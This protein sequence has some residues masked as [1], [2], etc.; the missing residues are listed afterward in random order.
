M[1]R[2]AAFSALLALSSCACAIAQSVPPGFMSVSSTH[3]TDFSGSPVSNATIFWA[4]VDGAGKPLAARI[5]TGGQGITVPV[6]ANIATGAF[7]IQVADTYETNP[8]NVCYSVTAIDNTDGQTLL[9]YPCV[10]PASSGQAW[11]TAGSGGAGG[12]CN[13]DSYI[14]ATPAGAIVA[15]G[16]TGPTGAT[17]PNCNVS[18]PPGYCNLTNVNAVSFD[19]ILYASQFAG[20]DWAGKIATAIAALPAGGGTI[21]VGSSLAGAATGALTVSAN[22]N[23]LFDCGTFALSGVLTFTGSGHKVEG[24]GR[25]GT[26]LKFTGATDG[27]VVQNASPAEKNTFVAHLTIETSNASGAA[28]YRADDSTNVTPP[29]YIVLEDVAIA[30]TGSGHWAYG[31]HTQNY[32]FNTFRDVVLTCCMTVAIHGDNS[33]NETLFDNTFV[34]NSGGTRGAE[35]YGGSINGSEVYWN[36]G[37]IQGASFSGS[38]LYVTGGSFFNTFGTHFEVTG[39]FSDG[40]AIVVADA[41]F[42]ASSSNM[43]VTFATTFTSVPPYVEISG[44]QLGATTL[45]SH[46]L[47]SIVNSSYQSITNNSTN[48]FM[49][50][51]TKF[52]G[53]ADN[54]LTMGQFL[55]QSNDPSNGLVGSWNGT[56]A[57]ALKTASYNA[58]FLAS[59]YCYAI[60]SS[61][62]GTV[63]SFVCRDG[64]LGAGHFN[65]GTTQGAHDGALAAGTV[66]TG[67]NV[68]YRCTT[69][70]ALP[71]GALTTNSGNCTA[72]TDTGM[73]TN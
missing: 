7:T 9:Q 3:L 23:L 62:F 66:S 25:V 71:V 41:H 31:I 61:T 70:G 19:G 53:S 69:A 38:A 49:A 57:F 43:G 29:I 67:S 46:T 45:D 6:S 64:S 20:S 26:I 14:P 55:L 12:T 48:F 27:V 11:C 13:F 22:V 34:I 28:A 50:G 44:S 1:K 36:G 2:I 72:S 52:S 18:S 58:W 17:G 56:K 54:N 16:P 37:G 4:P 5:G 59:N 68:V 47:G 65:F 40:A 10:Q 73:R 8:Q 63:D 51:N 15:V 42:S 24:C 39:P 33:T 60:S 35:F 32:Q 21:L 30:T